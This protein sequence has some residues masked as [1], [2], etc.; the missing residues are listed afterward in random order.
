MICFYL[1]LHCIILVHKTTALLIF[2]FLDTFISSFL[3][4]QF[5]KYHNASFKTKKVQISNSFCFCLLLYFLKNSVA[6][7][8]G[9]P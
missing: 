6:F 1:C 5:N 2:N 3:V 4:Q 7:S 9:N 8:T